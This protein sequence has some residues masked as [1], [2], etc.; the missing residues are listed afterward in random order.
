MIIKDL[1]VLL[2]EALVLLL[3]QCVQLI[4]VLILQTVL[5]CPVLSRDQGFLNQWLWVFGFLGNNSMLAEDI[6]PKY[7]TSIIRPCTQIAPTGRGGGMR[8]RC[9]KCWWDCTIQYPRW[10]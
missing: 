3:F 7:S 6:I 2:E 5:V 8:A 1:P 9:R 10:D 4:E